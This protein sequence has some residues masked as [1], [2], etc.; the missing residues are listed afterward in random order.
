MPGPGWSSVIPTSLCF[1]LLALASTGDLACR[2]KTREREDTDFTRDGRHADVVLGFKMLPSRRHVG[3]EL[4]AEFEIKNVA[5]Y[6]M[7]VHRRLQFG[8][9]KE[10]PLLREL[11]VRAMNEE[12][13]KIET[14]WRGDTLL[15]VPEDYGVL[16]PNESAKIEVDVS[17]LALPAGRDV[18]IATYDDA[19]EHPPPPPAGVFPLRSAIQSAA[20][21][22]EIVPR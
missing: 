15:A 14:D 9:E 7:W 13:R 21:N 22:L 6:P 18:L 19:S 4:I 11:S 5:P 3:E 16:A 17:C 12:G 8:D 1:V 20:V 2:L 10:P